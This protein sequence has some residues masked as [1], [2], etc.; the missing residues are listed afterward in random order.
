MIADDHPLILTGI[1]HALEDDGGFE[2]VGEASN[3]AQVV[4]LVAETQPDLALLDLK[5][6]Q[7]DGLTCLDRIRDRYPGVKVV[8]LSVSTDPELI[9]NVLNRGAA[10]YIVKSVNP[11]DLPSALRQALEGS[12][13]NAI[14]L[15]EKRAAADAAEAVGLTDR[16]TAILKAL[17]RG[18]SNEAIGTELWIAEQT[19][20]FHLTH[21]YRKLGVSNRAAAIHYAYEHNLVERPAPEP[22]GPH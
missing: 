10:A 2:V 9:Q 19:V 3:G 11:V 7:M 14:G 8:I 21:I 13:F 6:P 22:A 17:A 4:P 15:P 1:K 5:M 18:L 20:K 16:E 12:V